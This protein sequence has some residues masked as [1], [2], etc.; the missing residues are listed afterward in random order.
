MVMTAGLEQ[1][2]S[3]YHEAWILKRIAM[4]QTTLI[5]PAQQ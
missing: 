3:S 1:T 2:D 4:M 5:G